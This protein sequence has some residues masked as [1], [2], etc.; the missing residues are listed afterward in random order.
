MRE[1][2]GTA[3]QREFG[4]AAGELCARRPRPRREPRLAIQPWTPWVEDG[5]PC[6][7]RYVVDVMMDAA[8]QPLT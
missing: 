7:R 3:H 8:R 6:D 2:P 4:F 1:V 5:S